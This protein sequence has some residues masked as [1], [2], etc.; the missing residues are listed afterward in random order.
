MW[1]PHS[2]TRGSWPMLWRE[3]EACALSPIPMGASGPISVACLVHWHSPERPRGLSGLSRSCYQWA[4][5]CGGLVKIR[6]WI[7]CVTAC[8]VSCAVLQTF[9]S[10]QS[11]GLLQ[12][13]Q[14]RNH[15]AFS[16]W[17]A[18]AREPVQL[19]V[20]QLVSSRA[21][22]LCYSGVCSAPSEPETLTGHFIS[23]KLSL[24]NPPSVL[25]DT[26][27]VINMGD[28]QPE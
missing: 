19:E 6:R 15:C 8:P 18:H 27:L 22:G 14:S 23:S 5:F 26:A 21:A 7:A 28:V 16:T 4:R 17:G 9:S 11:L 13:L 2:L 25:W 24:S 20:A 1:G 10:L 12:S 3:E